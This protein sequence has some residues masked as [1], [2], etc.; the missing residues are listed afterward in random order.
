M[1]S[2][3]LM[4]A[5]IG[6]STKLFRSQSNAVST[7]AGR[8]DAQQNSRFALGNLDR[9]LRMAGGGVFNQ[10]PM[11]VMAGAM[12]ITFNADLVANDTGDIAAVYINP[13]ADSAGVD[14]LRK[15]N[16]ITLPGTSTLYP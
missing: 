1:I 14:V 6:L 12:G 16:R 15:A 5:V 11:L 7:Q 10:Q 3:S 9:E 2:M 4:L 8:L 13:D